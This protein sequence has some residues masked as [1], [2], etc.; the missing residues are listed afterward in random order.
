MTDTDT[1]HRLDH[2][3]AAQDAG[4]TYDQALAELRRG[5]KSSHWMWF[6]FPQLAGLGRSATSVKYAIADL[7]HARDYLAD[8]VLGR[9]LREAA[10]VV[11]DSPEP[12]AEAMFGGIDALKLQSSMTLFEAADAQA[13]VFARVLERYYGGR[14]CELT[15]R[16][17]GESASTQGD[18]TQGDSTSAEAGA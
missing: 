8:P 17:L 13:R 3:I 15:T 16:L 10:T 9:R 6:I 1:P 2:F 18:S 4:G 5:R 14:R 11:V 12:D 7:G